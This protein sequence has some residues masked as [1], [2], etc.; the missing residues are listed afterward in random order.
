MKIIGCGKK[1]G[2]MF[3]GFGEQVVPLQVT[4]QITI[5][6]LITNIITGIREK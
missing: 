2:E 3:G 4:Y 1:V 5:N 6:N